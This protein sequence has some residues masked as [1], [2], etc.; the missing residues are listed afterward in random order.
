MKRYLVIFTALALLALPVVLGA[1]ETQIPPE[2]NWTPTRPMW[3]TQ[4]MTLGKPSVTPREQ[5]RLTQAQAATPA[6]KEVSSQ[7][8]TQIEASQL[9]EWLERKGVLTAPEKAM[10]QQGKIPSA[11]GKEGRRVAPYPSRE[12]MIENAGAGE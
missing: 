12:Q 8:G 7:K 9:V 5:T 2:L 6:P 4:G 3:G 11:P 10:L 1:E